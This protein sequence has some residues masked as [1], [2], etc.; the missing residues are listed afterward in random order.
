MKKILLLIILTMNA[1]AASG[2]MLVRLRGLN[3]MPDESGTP[4][5]VGGE[6]KLNNESVPEIDF[7]YFL[8]D[9]LALELIVATATH[10]A[11]VYKASGNSTLDLGDVSL[12][13][14]TLT[15]QYHF[16]MGKFRPYV[17]AG[18]NYT[19][20]YGEDTG[21]MAT[22]NY[23]NAFGYALQVG[24]D[25]EISKDVFINFDIKKLML[26]TDVEVVTYNGTR[27]SAEVDIDPWIIG[28]G[29]GHRF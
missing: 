24:G 9:A 16:D 26:S 21:A 1:F 19:F 11:S 14:P 17:G 29:I 6:V 18:L 28:F 20:F 2:D 23:D 10:E 25:Y 8:S 13:P 7:T 12:L 22:V 27:V 3:V 5:V 4:T 15:L